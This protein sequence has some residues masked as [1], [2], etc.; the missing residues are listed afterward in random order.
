MATKC[1]TNLQFLNGT[2]IENL[3]LENYAGH[4][5][6][7]SDNVGIIYWNT[8]NHSVEVVTDT[9]IKQLALGGSYTLPAATATSL[10]G[11]MV[12]AESTGSNI[13][14]TAAGVIDLTVDTKDKIE[15]AIRGIKI[16][17]TSSQ[18]THTVDSNGNVDLGD[19]VIA[20]D[21]GLI[22][23]SYLPSYVDDVIE[24]STYNELETMKA[25]AEDANELTGKIYVLTADSVYSGVTYK[26]NT[27]FRYSG[28]TWVEISKT[29]D[30]A[31]EDEAKA[32]TSD[33][34]FMTPAKTKVAIDELSPVQKTVL[35]IGDGTE[36][37]YT[38]SHTRNSADLVVSVRDTATGE[39]VFTDVTIST[40]N[41]VISFAVPPTTDEYTVTIIG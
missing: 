39:V 35:K 1:L 15:K 41:V 28:T 19:V 29:P 2:Q 13:S 20:N 31:S 3:R 18:T 17:P 30:I 23:Q 32:G 5:A 14:V 36:K 26:A 6:V 7:T 40:S 9:E 10:G 21:K 27:Q 22:P 38:I 12:L 37:T 25:A 4:K 33:A 24:V 11:V 34:K 8:S 16:G